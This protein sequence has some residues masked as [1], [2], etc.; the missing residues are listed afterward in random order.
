MAG[1]IWGF[2]GVVVGALISGAVSCY[3]LR[4]TLA[5]QLRLTAA[6]RRLQ[7]HQQAFTWWR[8]LLRSAHQPKAGEVANECITWW[9]ENCLYLN[10]EARDALVI[11]AQSTAD[12]QTFKSDRTNPKL[13]RE[14]WER[15]TRAGNIIVASAQL[16]SFGQDTQKILEAEAQQS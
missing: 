7:A 15:I 11:A 5:A 10:A 16:P 9:E 1:A 14:N 4:E 8:K 6:E 12:H 3:V 2:I 13:V